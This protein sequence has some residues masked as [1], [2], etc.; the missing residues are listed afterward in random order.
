MKRR[1]AWALCAVI[2]ATSAGFVPQPAPTQAADELWHD[3]ENGCGPA[4]GRDVVPDNSAVLRVLF[5]DYSG[6][7]ELLQWANDTDAV[8]YFKPACDVHDRCYGTL[9]SSRADCD[10]EMLDDLVGVCGKVYFQKPDFSWK[11]WF[12]LK[13]VW[14]AI[15]YLPC[16]EAATTMYG[17]VATIG[18]GL[19][20][21]GTEAFQSAQA[22]ALKA[23]TCDGARQTNYGGIYLPATAIELGYEGDCS[24]VDL[25]YGDGRWAGTS[26]QFGNA[27][28]VHWLHSPDDVQETWRSLFDSGYALTNLEY[29]AGTWV[30]VLTTETGIGRQ[31]FTNRGTFSDLADDIR[32]A[33]DDG[34]TVT[35]IEHG[36][37]RWLMFASA[38]TGVTGQRWLR[39][40]TTTAELN[41]AVQRELDAGWWLTK[42]EHDG[43]HWLALFSQGLAWQGNGMT[44]RPT[45]H[46][47][48][49]AM[50]E[51][52]A[53]G[54]ML[55]DLEYGNGAWCGVWFVP[56]VV[57]PPTPSPTLQPTPAPTPM[58]TASPTPQLVDVPDLGGMMRADARALVRSR[59]LVFEVAGYRDM[60]SEMA[61]RVVDQD[62]LPYGSPVAS[63]STVRVWL[64]AASSFIPT[65][66][67]QRTSDRLT[68]W[69]P[70]HEHGDTI[71]RGTTVEVCVALHPFNQPEPPYPNW[72]LSD[73]YPADGPGA[74]I[75]GGSMPPGGMTQCYDHDVTGPGGYEAFGL[76]MLNP[77][78]AA[79]VEYADFWIYVP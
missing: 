8:T 4:K 13:T 37:G 42:L 3:F 61:G 14:K 68:I 47:T 31:F 56:L 30:T 36:D 44:C 69:L 33:W 48:R 20:V 77:S 5:G 28:E 21:L 38:G 45:Y 22:D 24:V 55:A 74:W 12:G 46:E 72:V 34:L 6:L 23:A 75:A 27:Q 73:F 64:G 51:H 15:Q 62:P 50:D 39:E 9:G 78:S 29:G 63:G 53:A 59:G 54:R 11:G 40:A 26:R 66:P 19:P 16:V 1:L 79:V 52:A 10:L 41:A 65:F 57:P 18:G 58:P 67:D 71:E 7:P 25:T 17:V 35:E 49:V 2:L 43:E 70:G 32:H 60:G 76:S